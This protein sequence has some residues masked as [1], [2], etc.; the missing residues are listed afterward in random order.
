MLNTLSN[1]LWYNY[2]MQLRKADFEYF[3]LKNKT[4]T[5]AILFCK[6]T[7]CC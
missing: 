3:V 4:C 1:I 5:V 7:I 2:N 6:P